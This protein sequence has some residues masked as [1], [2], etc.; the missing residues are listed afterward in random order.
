VGV[1]RGG[2]ALPQSPVPFYLPQAGEVYQIAGLVERNQDVE[3]DHG[4]PARFVAEEKE[5]E[6]SREERAGRPRSVLT[7]NAFE[8]AFSP[9]RM[10][11]GNPLPRFW[12]NELPLFT[13][14]KSVSCK[15]LRFLAYCGA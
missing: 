9:G 15:G 13:Q 14:V 7:R 8:H 3:P 12:Q 6:A 11:S 2:M 5:W 4:R 1:A 10:N